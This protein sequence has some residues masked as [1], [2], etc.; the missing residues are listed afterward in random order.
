MLEEGFH[1]DHQIF[2][3]KR[4]ERRKDRGDYV[5][6]V[7]P[8]VL[9]KYR[10]DPSTIKPNIEEILDY[11]FCPAKKVEDFLKTSEPGKAEVNLGVFRSALD[12][13]GS[14]L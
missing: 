12:V 5:G 1:Y 7:Y 6:K 10:G 14:D 13:L 11:T 4:K 3:G 8:G 9:I 2:P